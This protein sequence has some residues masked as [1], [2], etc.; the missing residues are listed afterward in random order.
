MLAYKKLLRINLSVTHF[1]VLENKFEEANMSDIK[2]PV[3]YN[4]VI[5]LTRS[6]SLSLICIH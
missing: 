3:D 4:Q 1:G 6:H 5:P 2:V